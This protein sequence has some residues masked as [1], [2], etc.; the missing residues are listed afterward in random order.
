MVEKS[1]VRTLAIESQVLGVLHQRQN[2][3]RR[4]PFAQARNPS[5]FGRLALEGFLVSV[6]LYFHERVK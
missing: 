4:G 2:Y 3:S 6:V 5:R 1:S